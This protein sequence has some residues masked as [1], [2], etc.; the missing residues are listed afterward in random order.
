MTKEFLELKLKKQAD[1]FEAF[2]EFDFNTLTRFVNAKI[3]PVKFND[4]GVFK[5]SNFIELDK[6]VYTVDDMQVLVKGMCDEALNRYMDE[7]TDEDTYTNELCHAGIW[8]EITK[9]GASIRYCPIDSYGS[10]DE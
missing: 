2:S 4:I 1:L 8:V 5:C 9:D 6:D 3:S 7:Y 10:C